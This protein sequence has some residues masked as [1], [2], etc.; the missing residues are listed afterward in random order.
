MKINL[1][2]IVIPVYNSEETLNDLFSEIDKTLSGKQNYELIL[3]DDGSRDHSWENILKLKE[4][5]AEKIKG[6]RLSKN[7]GQHNAI[8]CGFSFASGDAVL[9]MDDDLQHPPAEIPKLIQRF[10]ETN[11]DVVYG[12]YESKQHSSMRNAGSSFVQKSS[13]IAVG[14]SGLGSS[15]RLMKKNIAEQILSHR[16]QAQLF[17]D[18]ILHWYTTKFSTVEVE[19]H[20]R[21]AG[22]SG[23]TFLKLTT[24]Y[25][26]VVINYTA[27]PLK[28]MTWVGLFSSIVTF[29]L[30]VRFIYLKLMFGSK[31]GF[32][33]T[34]VTVLFATSLLMFCMGIIGQY[35]NKLYQL[36]N[37]RPAWSIDEVA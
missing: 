37:R 13:R 4:A 26:D 17:I 11:S 20:P 25:F 6:I 24:M 29:V 34:I 28:I 30:G 2:S 10:E 12:I 8:V 31:P 19:H 18:E 23:Y 7:F 9:T 3:V 5:N 36:Q 32:T 15:F 27:V 1:L 33:A 35:L 21:K 14:N 16:H 22:K